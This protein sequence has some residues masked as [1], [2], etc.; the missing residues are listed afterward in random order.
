VVER[1]DTTGIIETKI[2][3]P[4]GVVAMAFTH[5]DIHDHLVF[6]TKSQLPN[7]AVTPPG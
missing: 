7:V 1:S 3:H 5:L 6:T 4:G 2:P